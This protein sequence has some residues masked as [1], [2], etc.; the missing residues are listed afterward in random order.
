MV[1][2][3]SWMKTFMASVKKCKASIPSSRPVPEDFLPPNGER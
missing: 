1:M 3:Q 2:V